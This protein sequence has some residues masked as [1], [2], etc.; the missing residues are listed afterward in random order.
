MIDRVVLPFCQDAF[1]LHGPVGEAT[2]TH[3]HANPANPGRLV[4]CLP[5]CLGFAAGGGL[6]R[7][8]SHASERRQ[9]PSETR[10]YP[11]FS[12]VSK[13]RIAATR[14]SAA[15]QTQGARFGLTSI[16]RKES[17]ASS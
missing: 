11:R 9:F 12:T 4:A 2:F 3:R 16:T 14:S 17:L 6:K 10:T 1:T 7:Q 8:S 13:V 15:T 5:L